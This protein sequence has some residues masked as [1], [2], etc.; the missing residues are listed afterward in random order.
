MLYIVQCSEKDV[1]INLLSK[2]PCVFCKVRKLKIPLDVMLWPV[3]L[4]ILSGFFKNNL[5]RRTSIRR[6]LAKISLKRSLI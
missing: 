4:L 2:G 6:F 5:L 1:L 3:F